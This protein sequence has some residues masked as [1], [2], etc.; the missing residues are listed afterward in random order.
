[1]MEV[2]NRREEENKGLGRRRQR[3]R[4]WKGTK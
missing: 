1:M 2:W 3:K 4:R